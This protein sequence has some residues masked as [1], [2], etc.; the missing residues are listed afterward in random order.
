MKVV[1]R[2]QY[3][4]TID[5]ICQLEWDSLTAHDMICVA[6]AYYYFSI[7]FRENLKIARSIYP[8]D[9]KLKDLER[10]ECDTDN[11]SPWP[12]VADVGEK[13]N[14]DEYMRRVLEMHSIDLSQVRYF[15]S[16]GEGYL[17]EM[18]GLD[19]VSRA[20][21]IASYEDG[22]LERIFRAILEF[23][24]W[25]NALLG[26]FRHFLSEHIRFDC[27]PTQGHGALSRHLRPDDR[28]LP[29][30]SSFKSI[31]ITCVPRLSPWSGSGSELPAWEGSIAQQES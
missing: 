2:F 8:N 13:M 26:A 30:W 17:E 27:D 11:L 14:H 24:H 29:L 21:S 19:D 18:R 4:K 16:V 3:Q 6:W 23:R 20:L 28:V 22:G 7:Q 15:K 31:L 12:G 25:D 1:E 10:E 5:E 9:E